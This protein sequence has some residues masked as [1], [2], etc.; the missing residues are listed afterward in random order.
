MIWTALC[1]P[2]IRTASNERKTSDKGVEARVKRRT[3]PET[4]AKVRMAMPGR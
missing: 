2:G 1:E 3:T 4:I